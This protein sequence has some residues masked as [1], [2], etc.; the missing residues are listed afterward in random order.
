MKWLVAL[1][2]G[3]AIPLLQASR[4]ASLYQY[5][6]LSC[7]SDSLIGVSGAW[8]L[9]T[10]YSFGSTSFTMNCSSSDL[11]VKV[12]CTGYTGSACAGDPISTPFACPYNFDLPAGCSGGLVP[13]CESN[14]EWLSWPGYVQYNNASADSTTCSV[15]APAAV[16]GFSPN[17]ATYDAGLTKIS[18]QAVVDD[19]TLVVNT[20]RQGQ[21]QGNYTST[22]VIEG[23]NACHQKQLALGATYAA[24]ASASSQQQQQ[25]YGSSSLSQ[26]PSVEY[27]QG[28]L[29]PPSGGGGG[30]SPLSAGAIAGIA[31]GGTVLV[32]GGGALVFWRS[33]RAADKV[34]SINSPLLQ[35][36]DTA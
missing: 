7:D 25:V 30:S 34:A 36:Q 23:L 18:E 21:C 28:T 6:T 5:G 11:L 22:V 12:T 31:V 14:P 9:E 15:D 8:G 16:Y 2:L 27:A 32:G 24:S 33:R 20:Y 19:D 26:V 29:P 1:V 10:C 17:C 35:E 4:W 13:K 3:A